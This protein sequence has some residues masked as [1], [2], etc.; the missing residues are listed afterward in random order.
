[1]IKAGKQTEKVARVAETPEWG[2]GCLA[3]M[4]T[5][6]ARGEFR[7]SDPGSSKYGDAA[8]GKQFTIDDIYDNIEAHKLLPFLVDTIH[9][10]QNGLATKLDMMPKNE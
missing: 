7:N 2:G 1:M 4:T 9:A 3:Y 6:Q 10:V 8:Y 5:V